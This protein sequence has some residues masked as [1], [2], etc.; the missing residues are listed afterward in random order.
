MLARLALAFTSLLILGAP[1]LEADVLEVPDDYA[2]PQT[3][4]DNASPGDT[5]IIHGGTW[6]PITIDKP[7]S[8]VGAPSPTIEAESPGALVVAPITLDGP[9]SG[10]VTLSRIT[11]GGTAIGA[12]SSQNA[13]GIRGGGFLEL[14]VYDSEIHAPEWCCLTGLGVGE[15]GIDV[16]V[17]FILV[18][19][20]MV[21]GART[22]TDTT[23]LTGGVDGGRGI[24]GPGTLVVLDSTVLGGD[25]GF[26]CFPSAS[27]DFGCPGGRGGAGIQG[28]TL[29]HAGSTI[30]GGA[31]AFWK[32]DFGVLCC[33]YDN[34]PAT[35]VGTEVAMANELVGKRVVLGKR[36]TLHATAPGPSAFLLS[37][38]D[39]DPPTSTGFGELFLG[40]TVFLESVA[41]PGDIEIDFPLLLEM[42]GREVGF[43][44]LDPT[45]GLSRPVS[46]A[47]LLPNLQRASPPA[48]S[49]SRDL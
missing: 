12:I 33:Q 4:I 7:L 23:Q 27:C 10:V 44:L 20:S 8:L 40:G 18:E 26:F 14:H 43:Q 2:D 24:A 1:S 47:L 34:G 22:D 35:A 17:P 36:Y 42:T 48:D 30:E 45:G 15:A 41:T 31:G 28:P 29:Y 25:S 32:D 38:F 21:T 37:S 16:A 49:V 6:P 5:I 39:V 3:A 46:S 19:R 11:V 9:G 13:P